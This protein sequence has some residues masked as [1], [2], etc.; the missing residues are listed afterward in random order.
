MTIL[1]GADLVLPGR[2][3]T[4]GTVVIDGGPHHRGPRR[5]ARGRRGSP[6]PSRA[7]GFI[8]V[9]VHG[10][11]G[12]DA[13]DEGNAVDADRS[14]AAAFRRH[15][16]LPDVDRV[17]ARRS[18]A[19]AVRDRP[20][21][22]AAAGRFARA[23]RP[24]RKQLH[25]PRVQRCAAGRVPAPAARHRA[26]RHVQRQGYPRRHRRGALQRRYPDDRSGVRRRDSS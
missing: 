23:A 15:R 22:R 25:Q 6:R 16:V 7:P 8:D 21:A 14:P 2:V 26:R 13:L 20:G 19:H 18:L 17:L 4:A 3:V 12:L 10:L 5:T 9:H 11:H 24:P 1:S